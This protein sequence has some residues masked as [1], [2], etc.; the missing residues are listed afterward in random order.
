MKLECG[1]ERSFSLFCMRWTEFFPPFAS[2]PHDA[3]ALGA[4]ASRGALCGA[5]ASGMHFIM[6][7]PTT[8]P[9]SH[10]FCN[11]APC[12]ARVFSICNWNRVF[13]LLRM[14]DPS[15]ILWEGE[16]VGALTSHAALPS[17]VDALLRRSDGLPPGAIPGPWTF[18]RQR[19][20]MHLRRLLS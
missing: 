15:P 16:G 13:S 12:C 14:V 19:D 10:S 4:S 1:R 20:P 11:L 3:D 5:P 8:A 6:H 2:S 9:S 17:T 18:T 7:S